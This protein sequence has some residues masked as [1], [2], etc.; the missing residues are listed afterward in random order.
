MALIIDP[1]LLQAITPQ[2]RPEWSLWQKK[3]LN[4][5]RGVMEFTA[6]PVNS[7]HDLAGHV[8]EGVRAE[9]RPAWWRGFGFG[10]VIH[11]A[12]LPTDFTEICR[13]VDTRNRSQGVWQWVV[14]CLDEDRI[15]LAIHT[16]LHGYLRPVY[17]SVLHQLHQSG[18]ECHAVD[19]EMDAL[20]AQLNRIARYCRLITRVAG[21]VA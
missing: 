14:I 9:F 5:H 18:Y 12:E 11:C 1:Q 19:A 20:I 13:H 2:H 8:R 15:A 6:T 10:A 7:I 3:S 16:W 17:D 21:I 4:I